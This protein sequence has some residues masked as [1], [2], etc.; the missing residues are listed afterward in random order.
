MQEQFVTKN[1]KIGFTLMQSPFTMQGETYS[2]ISITVSAFYLKFVGMWLVEN[3]EDLLRRR[4][5][6][7][8]TIFSTVLTMSCEVRD[9]YFS[10]GDFN[11]AIYVATNNV[12]V[13]LILLKVYVIMANKIEFNEL[14]VFMRDHFW[15]NDYDCYEKKI[16]AN[17]SKTC[18]SMVAVNVFGAHAIVTIQSS[19]PIFINMGK[20]ETDRV[21][22]FNM[23][24]GPFS[25]STPYYE[26]LYIIQVI[27]Y[28]HIAVCF[29]C[30]DN[31]FCIVNMH[32]SAQFRIVQY[33]LVKLHNTE[34]KM[35]DRN[36]NITVA[37]NSS[38]CYEKLKSCIRH[39]QNLI[40]YCTKIEKVFTLI[41][42]GEMT[43]VSGLICLYGYQVFLAK[44]NAMRRW[45]F[46][47]LMIGTTMVLL[48]FIYSCHGLMEQ[49]HNVGN[50]AYST[51]WTLMPMNK[52]GRNLRN[53]LMMVSVRSRRVC[54]LT[55]NGFFPIS[56]ETYTKVIDYEYRGI[57]LYVIERP[58]R[59]YVE[60]LTA[61]YVEHF[62]N[63][64]HKI[65]M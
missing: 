11:N 44:A 45:T 1:R 57:I 31:I 58:D 51:P 53:D 10:W 54:C 33:R 21:H 49:S 32:V 29:F 3:D 40:R 5:A 55:A 59:R 15:R 18:T 7:C 34:E 6:V 27:V 43:L 35:K 56:L 16:L 63:I 38:K 28:Y 26:M 20:N 37:M 9:L 8:C 22:P 17:T 42:L 25:A 65:C 30:F 23:W 12:S 41:V 19:T 62:I 46:G 60:G 48:M 50:A 24:L 13:A 64:L 52:L 36:A 47:L 14:I 39:H 61:M 2:D 4:I